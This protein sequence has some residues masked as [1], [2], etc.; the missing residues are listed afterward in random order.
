MLTAVIH[1][2]PHCIVLKLFIL[3]SFYPLRLM[4]E[5]ESNELAVSQVQCESLPSDS[6]EKGD[7]SVSWI[8]THRINPAFY[9]KL[10]TRYTL[11]GSAVTLDYLLYEPTT[12]PRG[13]IL[14]LTGGSFDA[15]INSKDGR[16]V[17]RSGANFLIRSAHYF[18]AR[19]YRV[20]GLNRPD[21]YRLYGNVDATP[22]LYD[23][24]RIS[25]AHAVDIAMVVRQHHIA[26]APVI[27]VGSSRGVISAYA[28]QTLANATVLSSPVTSGEGIPLGSTALPLSVA[29]RPSVVV[30]HQADTCPVSKPQNTRDFAQTMYQNGVRVALTAITGGIC[31]SVA[32]SP[33]S[34]LDHHGFTGIESCSV[35][36]SI[37]AVEN[38]LA[39]NSPDNH[40]P[41]AKDESVSVQNQTL[42]FNV[43]AKDIDPDDVLRYAVPTKQTVLGG[44]IVIDSDS[45]QV[46]YQRPANIQGVTDRF[47]YSVSDGQGGVSV[48]IVSLFLK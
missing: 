46:N 2:D 7:G 39:K 34:A 44:K 16:M 29:V 6:Y 42:Q 19:G 9:Y 47:V 41:I 48:G 26:N 30:F 8:P 17:N 3:L 14:L 45:G 36:S 28:Q 27:F 11:Q 18:A 13:L 33:C 43:Q 40:F 1:R 10:S 37:D 15:G 20:I 12:K 4:A 38:L 23:S 5:V 25:M 31:D 32:E 22:N 35:N 24:Y 21:D